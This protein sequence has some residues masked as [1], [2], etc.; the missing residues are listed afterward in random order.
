MP[1]VTVQL[2]AG[3]KVIWPRLIPISKSTSPY[4]KRYLPMYPKAEGVSAAVRPVHGTYLSRCHAPLPDPS[5]NL[6]CRRC[7]TE[8]LTR[9]RR[10]YVVQYVVRVGAARL[11][12]PRRGVRRG[13]LALL[14]VAEETAMFP[15]FKLHRTPRSASGPPMPGHPH[16]MPG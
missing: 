8:G 11:A 7:S 15:E 13:S 5:A 2:W 12:F 6:D 3:V 10:R 9:D 16:P 14:A 1:P 4:L